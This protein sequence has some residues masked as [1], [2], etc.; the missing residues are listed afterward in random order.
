MLAR[1]VRVWD[2]VSGQEKKRISTRGQGQ[3]LDI[4]PDG[5]FA[6]AGLSSGKVLYLDLESGQTL[7]AMTGHS[8]SI[9]WVAFGG[10]GRAFS[11]GSDGTVRRWKLSDGKEDICLR[12]Q[13]KRARGAAV[14]PD[15][16][17]LLTGDSDGFLQFWDLHTK[18]ETR[19]T[20]LSVGSF[21]NSLTLTPGGKQVLI[22][23]VGGARLY[24]LE[25]GQEIRNFLADRE[26]V[27]SSALSPDGSL[28]LTASFDGVIRLWDFA[29]A[30][31]RRELGRHDGFAFSVA[32]SPDGKIGA[33]AGGG[34]RSGDQYLPG[35]D[36]DIRLWD[37]N[38]TTTAPEP[39]KTPWLWAAGIIFTVVALSFV[40][41]WYCL[42][43]GSR[44]QPSAVMAPVEEEKNQPPV[45]MASLV[46]TCSHC[47]QKLKGNSE[48][49]GKT[50]KCPKCSQKVV[51]PAIQG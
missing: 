36:H 26:E 27:H 17:R 49:A 7:Q 5:R 19:R 23:S 11:A 51:V 20:K 2:L 3:A 29:T 31:L 15:G 35:T 37:L 33:S 1:S 9:G 48:L 39:G 16:K 13:G 25:T 6:L 50:I 18:K 34:Q 38:T 46:V 28:L 45:V 12:V 14:F 32:F 21:I 42:R 47:G 44:L 4:T 24:D 41:S 10:D 8:R 22:S 43:R 30:G 40:G